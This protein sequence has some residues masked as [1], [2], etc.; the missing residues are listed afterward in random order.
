MPGEAPIAAV[1]LGTGAPLRTSPVPVVAVP[2]AVVP[3][4]AAPPA[5]TAVVVT[6]D[7]PTAPPTVADLVA[8]AVRA[9]PLVADLH[10]GAFGEV[11]TYLPGRRIPG[12]RIDEFA[13]TVHVVA[14]FPAVLSQVADEVRAAVAPYSGAKA[15][16]VVIEDIAVPG[17]RPESAA[18]GPAVLTADPV[19]PVASAPSTA[20]PDLQEFP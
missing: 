9:C 8:A 11:A 19:G 7:V 2:V 12:I 18:T 15:V 6:A 10:G 13:I 1:P 16:D 4:D 17:A 20:R 14:R 3:V 5:G